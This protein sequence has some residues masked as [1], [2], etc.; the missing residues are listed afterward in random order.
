MSGCALIRETLRRRLSHDEWEGN[1]PIIEREGGRERERVGK[2]EGERE[3]DGKRTEGRKEGEEK[4]DRGRGR[5]VRRRG[6][7]GD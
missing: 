5:G 4:K 2:E 3:G 1:G 6:K 7:G